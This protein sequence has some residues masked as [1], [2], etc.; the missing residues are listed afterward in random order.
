[1]V[2]A[3]RRP[4]RSWEDWRVAL[5]RPALR[6]TCGYCWGAG[7]VW[8]ISVLGLVPVVCPVCANFR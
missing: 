2:K 3:G 4:Y 7:R 1:V 8:D 5:R 6:P